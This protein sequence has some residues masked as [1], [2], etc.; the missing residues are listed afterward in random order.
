MKKVLAIILSIAMLF[1]VLAINTFAETTPTITIDCGEAVKVG[2]TTTINVNLTNFSGVKGIDLT[3]TAGEGIVFTDVTSAEIALD[4]ETNINCKLEDQTFH[5]VDLTNVDTATI[6]ITATVNADAKVTA[7]AQLAKD[8]KVLYASNE[9]SIVDGNVVV[10]TVEMKGTVSGSEE[11]PVEF[12]NEDEGYFIPYGS[13]YVKNEDGSFTYV[14]KNEYGIFNITE[15]GVNWD[16][17][18][19]PAD[20]FGTFALSDTLNAMTTPAVQFATYSNKYATAT[21]H[22][23]MIIAGDWTEFK[24]KY[25]TKTEAELI[26]KISEVY[27]ANIGDND[28]VNLTFNSKVNAIRI[29]KIN[30]K[31]FMWKNDS[32]LEYALRVNGLNANDDYAAVG[33]YV[34]DDKINFSDTV[35]SYTYAVNE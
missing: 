29:K 14:K 9:F 33:Y 10:K 1:G 31:N 8:S 18:E 12:K 24:A 13:V 34:A 27:D 20:G 11:A 23:T 6:A 30:Q 17:F 28:Y 22:G 3:V 15:S 32:V 4:R 5:I 16:K 2:E 25:S 21:K 7:V 26:A 35:M 19:I